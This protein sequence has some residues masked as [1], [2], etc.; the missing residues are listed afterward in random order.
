MPIFFQYVLAPA[1]AANAIATVVTAPQNYNA[2]FDSLKTW[3]DLVKAAAASGSY[4][5]AGP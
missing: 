3:A 1:G 5:L 4:T 2:S